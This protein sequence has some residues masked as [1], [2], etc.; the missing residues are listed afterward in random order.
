MLGAVLFLV[1]CFLIWPAA[2]FLAFF[3]A[4]AP[5]SVGSIVERL[6]LLIWFFPAAPIAGFVQYLVARKRVMS[7]WQCALALRSPTAMWSSVV[8]KVVAR[9]PRELL[10]NL[11]GLAAVL[12]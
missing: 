10:A 5:G 1:A 4:D 2:A 3:A 11:N 6:I 8:R 7:A 9:S 12:R